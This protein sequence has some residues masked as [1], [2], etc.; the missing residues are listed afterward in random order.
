MKKFHE[1]KLLKKVGCI[2]RSFETYDIA[3]LKKLFLDNSE[4][5]IK[6][7]YKRDQYIFKEGEVSQGLYIL[8]SGEVEITKYSKTNLP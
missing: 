8:K 2:F 3:Y 4:Y 5:F 7:K 1:V 6:K